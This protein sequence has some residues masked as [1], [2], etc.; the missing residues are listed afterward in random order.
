MKTRR[1]NKQYLPAAGKSYRFGVSES[2][3]VFSSPWEAILFPGLLS[4]SFLIELPCR[5]GLLTRTKTTIC[6]MN[7]SYR[8][9]GST[10]ENLEYVISVTQVI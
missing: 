10:E 7:E 9:P 1:K 3:D 4:L 5:L 6:K 8:L 2:D